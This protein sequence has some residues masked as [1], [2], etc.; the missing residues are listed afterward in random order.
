MC[1]VVVV[2]EQFHPLRT[3]IHAAAHADNS[4]GLGKGCRRMLVRVSRPLPEV[5]ICRQLEHGDRGRKGINSHCSLGLAAI[6]I[7]RTVYCQSVLA[8]QTIGPECMSVR[9]VCE[10]SHTVEVTSSSVQQHPSLAEAAGKKTVLV[11]GRA[12]VAAFTNLT[13]ARMAVDEV[14]RRS[15]PRRVR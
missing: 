3:S 9:K 15:I 8:K 7:P 1:C 6:R 14:R 2:R 10:Y 5:V 12:A 4:Q 13:L 11:E